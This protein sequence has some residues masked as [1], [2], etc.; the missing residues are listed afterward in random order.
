[1]IERFYADLVAHG[2]QGRRPASRPRRSATPTWSCA[3]PWPTASASSCSIRNP[4]ARAKPPTG[5]RKETPTWTAAEVTTFLA[6]VDGRPAVRPVGRCSPPPA[7]AGARPSAC[8]GA[9]STSTEATALGQPDDH[10]RRTT[11]SWSPRPRAT[12]AVAASASTRTP[13]GSFGTIGGTRSGTASSSDRD[14][15]GDRSCSPSPTAARSTP[16]YVTRRF[17]TPRPPERPAAAARPARP[18]P[19]LGLARP[20]RRRP[21]QGRLRPPRPLDDRHHDRHLQPRHPQP[22]R[23]RRGHRRRP[24][25]RRHVDA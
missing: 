1:M 2:W 20:R 22:R 18:P 10:D 16:T 9:T 17:K 23:R 25:L 5:E 21:P 6:G 14:P 11:R 3:R 24:A 7:C 12:A 19:H 8:A 15:V 4:A 13:F